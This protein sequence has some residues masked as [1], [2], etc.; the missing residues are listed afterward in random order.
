MDFVADYRADRRRER[1]LRWALRLI[2]LAFA[3]G[4]VWVAI[5]HKIVEPEYAALYIFPAVTGVS[6][7]VAIRWFEV[8]RFVPALRAPDPAVRAA[9]G[10]ALEALRA[11][12]VPKLLMLSPRN[13]DPRR[14]GT[15]GADEL[16]GFVEGLDRAD[17]RKIGPIY[18]VCYAVVLV[19]TVVSL[20]LIRPGN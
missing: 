1:A 5:V 4:W 12:V 15:M 3:A 18:F 6:Q 2:Q 10:R 17:W 14:A 8:P 19:V 7:I 9:A 20:A 16:A 11:E 13:V